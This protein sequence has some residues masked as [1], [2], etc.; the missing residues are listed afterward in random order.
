MILTGF[1]Y[2]GFVVSILGGVSLLRPIAIFGIS[3]RA[4][5]A[6]LLAVGA[7][8]VAIGWAWP[9]GERRVDSVRTR[10]DELVPVSQFSERHSIRVMASRPRVYRAIREVTAKEI[11]LFRVLT[12]IR[13]LGRPGRESILNAPGDVPL[14]EVATRTGFA[15]LAEEPDREIV[16]GT[17]VMFPPGWRFSPEDFKPPHAPGLALAAMNFRVEDA[18]PGVCIVTTETRV[19]ASDGSARR[20]FAIY[21]RTI[22]P[23]SALIR[24]M[25]LRAVKKR[26]ESPDAD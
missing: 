11:R 21:W 24:R 10:L 15:Q 18:T 26:A 5:G 22:Y 6:I 12:W 19:F 8:L 9:T 13:R 16:I 2:A 3:N 1:V 4:Q 23:G 7:T 14:L 20:R 25:W 17:S